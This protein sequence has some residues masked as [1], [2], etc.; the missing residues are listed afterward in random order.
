[1]AANGVILALIAGWLLRPGEADPTVAG[2]K[3]PSGV[4]GATPSPTEVPIPTKAE[5]MG[6]KGQRFG[7]SAP[8]V[9]WSAAKTER[10]STAAGANPSMMMVFVKWTEEFRVEPIE[11]CYERGALPVL[12]WEPWAGNDSGTSQPKYALSK[13]IDG[14]YDE[15]VTRFATAVRD[16]R[17]PVAIRFAH[18]M[19]GSW[20]PWSESR[21]GNKKGQYVRAWRHVHDIFQKVG[22]TNVIWIWSPNILRPVPKVSIAAL[23]PGDDYVDWAGMV[24][25]AVKESTAAPVFEPTIKAIRKVTQK[26]IVITETGVQPGPRKVGW[27]TNFFAWLPKHPDV[28]GFI[29]FE[30]SKEQGGSADWRYTATPAATTA[31]KAGLKSLKP[32]PGPAAG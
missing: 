7:L 30:Y 11:L 16:A 8:D 14:S 28:I 5:I 10:L 31:F 1:M 23:Y 24:G 25:Y 9:P 13:I 20:Y 22:T 32:A 15:Y 4:A 2:T 21:S 27:I 19:N 29:W 17:W 12:S 6:I 18:E 3:P 26:P